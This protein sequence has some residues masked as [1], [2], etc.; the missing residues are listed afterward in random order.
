MA[1]ILEGIGGQSEG[2]KGVSLD[3]GL[4]QLNITLSLSGV[5]TLTDTLH[6]TLEQTEGNV[7]ENID[8]VV[9]TIR[10]LGVEDLRRWAEQGGQEEQ[11]AF[12]Q[13][14]SRLQQAA[15]RGQ[16]EA[17]KLLQNFGGKIAQA[18]EKV[19]KTSSEESGTTH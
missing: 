6:Q 1:G 16:N 15:Q 9:N 13:L 5:R 12:N 7:T 14:V 19:Q 3:L 2:T 8:K 11:N 10:Q 18:G 17:G 4:L